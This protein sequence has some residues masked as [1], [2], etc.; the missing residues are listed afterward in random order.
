MRNKAAQLVQ[1]LQDEICTA[2][3]NL[4]DVTFIEDLW[5]RPEG[6]G[7][8]TRVLTGGSV[9]AKA[10]V[11]V[12][13][14]HGELSDAAASAMLGSAG[15]NMAGASRTFFA[16]GISLVLHPRNPFVPI[17][18]ANYRYFERGD[19]PAAPDAWWFGGGADLTPCYLFEEDAV[20]FHRIHKEACDRHGVA[21]YQHF[22][23]LCDSYFRIQHRG[24]SRGIG[25]IFF[26]GLNK[27]S[28]D[29]IYDFIKDV[30][31]QFVH[32]Y[33]PIV[34]KRHNTPYGPEHEAWQL[35]RRGRYV[36]FNLVYDRGTQF[37]LH[38]GG[39]TE[40]ILMSLPPLAGWEYCHTPQA[41]SSESQ[42]LEVLKN[43]RDWV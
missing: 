41:G 31:S 6:G 33:C 4:D 15:G 40:S 8:R 7:G 36:E 2:L 17:V 37:G 38:T 14:V 27:G 11:N 42:L 24:E 28:P 19:E 34:E 26:D 1:T 10:G 23:K 13:V 30:G 35:I 21:D 43:P 18:H 20:H 39:R 25:G 12:S 16:T 9:F 5:T 3:E 32:A 22:K 29:A